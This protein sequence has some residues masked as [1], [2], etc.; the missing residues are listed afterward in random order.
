MVNF[1]RHERPNN[2]YTCAFPTNSTT[3]HRPSRFGKIGPFQ[4]KVLA[5]YRLTL[6]QLNFGA[7]KIGENT[8]NFN[9][10]N[11]TNT[12]RNL[13]I[14]MHIQ[15][16][17]AETEVFKTVAHL[18]VSELSEIQLNYVLRDDGPKQGLLK[19]V[20][21]TPGEPQLYR[22]FQ[23][24]PP[25]PVTVEVTQPFY[26]HRIFADQQIGQIQANIRLNLREKT[27]KNSELLVQV[28]DEND[29]VVSSK[30]YDSPKTD[31]HV[32]LP[33]QDQPYGAY[34]LVV[35]VRGASGQLAKQSVLIRHLS[36]YPSAVRIDDRG[37]L[38]VDNAPFFP[39][40]F[41]AFNG[42][43][44]DLADSGV[45]VLMT[46]PREELTGLDIHYMVPLHH[47]YRKNETAEAHR[48]VRQFQ[49]HPQVLGWY[50]ADEPSLY[51]QTPQDLVSYIDGLAKID[52]YH[53]TFA[54]YIKDYEDYSH[55]AD[56]FMFD[57]YIYFNPDTDEMLRP[58]ESVGTL[59]QRAVEAV[60]GKRPV[61]AVLGLHAVE[62]R[63]YRPPTYPE[64]RCQ[65]YQA[66][67][68]GA[69]G[70]IWFGFGGWFNSPRDAY[71]LWF[72]IKH[73][74][75]E[76]QFLSPA[77]LST[78]SIDGFQVLGNTSKIMCLGKMYDGELYL[79]CVNASPTPQTLT[80]DIGSKG[81]G[82]TSLDVFPERRSV[83]ISDNQF[84]DQFDGYA[85]HI[86][87]TADQPANL[88]P[89]REVERQYEQ[90]RSEIEKR[91]Q[92]DLTLIPGVTVKASSAFSPRWSSVLMTIDGH[93]WAGGWRLPKDSRGQLPQ[94]LQMTWPKP[95]RIGRVNVWGSV[96]HLQLSAKE[97]EDWRNI[98]HTQLTSGNESCIS[99]GFDPVTTSELR[100]EVLEAEPN[101]KVLIRE[102]EVLAP[103]NV[104]EA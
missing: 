98:T 17:N 64:V 6:S 73:L 7:K 40:G 69:Q 22:S 35:D 19:V 33:F 1:F 79:V 63:K 47:P 3:S 86:Y 103:L 74:T 65:V 89:L 100:I 81:A 20:N 29:R 97:G 59:T 93:R 96:D 16:T 104:D 38:I 102:V 45:N 14:E 48:K 31:Q 76:L 2:E 67:A 71:D 78:E 84:T 9:I 101:T 11:D 75:R 39:I 28:I 34:Q 46:S 41:Y 13:D 90:M 66:V 72:G 12:V 30:E 44:S 50:I 23:F 91:R 99:V 24:T 5:P 68:H 52:P 92:Q 42:E 83:S 87:T 25:P 82:L 77:L 58:I 62:V 53:P 70:I 85:V 61:I 37:R 4:E 51:D 94:W 88:T 15:Q 18:P 32:A 36:P 95:V 60:A 21:Q 26:G 54:I 27:L 10:K 49:H 8:L 80:F 55:T 43:L 56:V 57:R